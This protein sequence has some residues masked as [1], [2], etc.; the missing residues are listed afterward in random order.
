MREF[1]YLQ[2]SFRT[3]L[4]LLSALSS[5]PMILFALISLAV[6]VENQQYDEKQKL[7]QAALALARD[8]EQLLLS[9]TGV[10]VAIAS[11]DSARA[12]DV[13]AVYKLAARLVARNPALHAIGLIDAN[14][15]ILFNTLEPYG[16]KLPDTLSRDSALR[17]IETKRPQ[18]S[19]AFYGV[20]SREMVTALGVPLF[21]NN[22][23]RYSLRVIIPVADLN[24]ILRQQYFPS[25][26]SAALRA[27]HVP[28]VTRGPLYAKAAGQEEHKEQIVTAVMD[29]GHWGWRVSVSVPE[30]AF[31]RPLRSLLFKFGAVGFACAV[32]GVVASQMLSRRLSREITE[33]ATA[34]ACLPEG[35]SA[36]EDHTL[37][38][39]MGQV[40]A[41]LLAAKDRE[42][43]AMI[44]QLTGLPGRARFWELAE[45]I[46]E[47]CRVNANQGLALMFL[48]LDGFKQINDTF[49]HDRGDAM[50]RDVADILGRNVRDM[51]VAGRLGGDEFAICLSAGNEHLFTASAAI[52]ERI[53]AQVSELGCGIGCSIGV[54]LCRACPVDL[55]Q[56]LSLADQAMYEAK[57]LG[58][59]RYTIREYP[60][61]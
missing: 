20:I 32:L 44:D 5:L 12:D 40:R 60:L 39:E 11:T 16:K 24:R 38:R 50:L 43:Q 55:A 14:G 22:T 21:V 29:V 8:M 53:I 2:V 59:N 31:V 47:N 36:F 42:E 4:A 56:A 30:S 34:S 23:A 49:G 15:R 61:A 46:E 6:L 1:T 35:D 7:D 10:L 58:K 52:A 18:V 17:V 51:D 37:I 33:L 48:D 9:R 26:W 28:I 27:G 57:R 45:L 41:N 54:I 19:K 25:S 13:A 3:W